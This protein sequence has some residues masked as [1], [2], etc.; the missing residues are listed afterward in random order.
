[1]GQA[2]ASEKNSLRTVPRNFPGRS[3]TREDH[4]WLCGPA[5]AAASALTGEISDPRSLG[6]PPALPR[7]RPV[8]A[9]RRMFE[10][11]PDRGD[12]LQLVKGPNIVSLPR[13][14]PIADVLD[15]PIL[16]SLGDDISTDE[17]LPAGPCAATSRRSRCS[18]SSRST[19]AMSHGRASRA[20]T[21]SRP[22]ATTARGPVVSTLP[23]R[24]AS[25]GCALCWRAAS[26]AFTSRT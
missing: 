26:R 10:P 4:V 9:P 1:M 16:L 15:V 19:I 6:E 23:W 21:Q 8:A 11:P 20:S 17:I 25:W 22:A 14:S 13:L 7:P 12:D 18:A 24:R 3:G 2:P 5:V